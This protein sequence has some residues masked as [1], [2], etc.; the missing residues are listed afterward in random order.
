MRAQGWGLPI[1]LRSRDV[2]L[3]REKSIALLMGLTFRLSHSRMLELRRYCKYLALF[4]VRREETQSSGEFF[5]YRLIKASGETVLRDMNFRQP[6]VNYLLS[7]EH[8]P[9]L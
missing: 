8:Q 4:L 9:V 2:H 3:G 1:E 5:L 7:L 6:C